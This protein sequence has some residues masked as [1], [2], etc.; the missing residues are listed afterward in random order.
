M[1]CRVIEALSWGGTRAYIFLANFAARLI[2]AVTSF[3]LA[4]F[5]SRIAAHSRDAFAYPNSIAK[6][7][8]VRLFDSFFRRSL[9]AMASTAPS[10]S[11]ASKF[12][13][14]S[15]SSRASISCSIRNNR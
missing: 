12:S 6:E 1:S 11:A 2:F 8:F 5:P 10:V 4:I 9:R 3:F 7:S 15:A 14:V 13:A